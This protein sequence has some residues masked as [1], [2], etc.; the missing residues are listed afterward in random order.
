MANKSRNSC[1]VCSRRIPA[2][3]CSLKCDCCLSF[4]HKN[5]TTLLKNE[6][7]DIVLSKRPWSCLACNESNFAFN[8]L[9]EEGDFL[10]SLSHKCTNAIMAD[11]PS[12]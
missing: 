7:Q 1:S 9:H 11:L 6:I 5:C 10:I 8:H 3:A 2:N 12:D 4:I